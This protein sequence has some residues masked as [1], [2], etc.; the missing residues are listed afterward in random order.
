MID[1][2]YTTSTTII[3]KITGNK[4]GPWTSNSSAASSSTDKSSIPLPTEAGLAVGQGE[5]S[6]E[7]VAMQGHS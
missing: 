6:V 7:E 1:N 3:N 5:E 4:L 2:F